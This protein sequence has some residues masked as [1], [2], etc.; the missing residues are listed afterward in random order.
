MRTELALPCCH[1]K[2]PP[3]GRCVRSAK[4]GRDCQA[5]TDVTP[6]PYVP[7]VPL[8]AHVWDLA[9]MSASGDDRPQNMRGPH[10]WPDR[11]ARTRARNMTRAPWH[12]P[13]ARTKRNP[14]CIRF[15]RPSPPPPDANFILRFP[16][17]LFCSSF[18]VHP[19]PSRVVKSRKSAGIRR[20]SREN[21][22]FP[23]AH[24]CTELGFA[25]R[26]FAE[27]AEAAHRIV[28]CSHG[29]HIAHTPSNSPATSHTSVRIYLTP[30]P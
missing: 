24:A 17:S 21:L 29:L 6:A 8:T 13:N 26:V 18:I 9:S 11:F 27:L 19:F 28:V 1:S 22:C 30:V 23:N 25:R 20:N 5:A 15:P 3:A 10:M 2:V 4:L 12:N 16:R 14:P 7:Y